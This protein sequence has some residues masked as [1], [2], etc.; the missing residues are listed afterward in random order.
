M[1]ALFIQVDCRH[2]DW[3]IASAAQI[4]SM[5]GSAF[6]VIEN[7]TLD[8]KEHWLSG[9]SSEWFFQADRTQW[10]DLRSFSNVKTLQVANKLISQLSHSLQLEDGESPVELLPEL[11]ELSFSNARVL[12]YSFTPLVNARE[13]DDAPPRRSPC[14]RGP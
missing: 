8:L 9:L 13:F 7:V 12:D 4:F 11:K 1:Y 3:Q 2:L 6:S 10:R 5:L 14:D